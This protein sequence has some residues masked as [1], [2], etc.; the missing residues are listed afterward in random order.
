MSPTAAY[1]N[2]NVF[3]KILRNEM[4]AE[5]VYEDEHTLAIMDIMPRTDGHVLVIP[6][7]PARNMLD[8]YAEPALDPSVDQALCEF[9]QKREAELPEG[10][11]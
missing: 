4:P 6:K 3:A 9:I 7:T 2:D 11:S 10:V 1:D 5:R 8:A